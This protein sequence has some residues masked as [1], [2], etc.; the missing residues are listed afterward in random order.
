MRRV[1]EGEK[2]TKLLRASGSII[3]LKYI[4]DEKAPIPLFDNYRLFFDQ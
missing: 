4:I 3:N 2:R 1:G